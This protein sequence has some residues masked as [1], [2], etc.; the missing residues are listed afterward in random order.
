M[1]QPPYWIRWVWKTKKWPWWWPKL[2]GSSNGSK[3][4]DD[5]GGT[6]IGE[7]VD[8]RADFQHKGGAHY[9]V[10]YL[11]AYTGIQ[12][13]EHKGIGVMERHSQIMKMIE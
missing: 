6:Y 12:K 9:D 10:D 8:I 4:E 2:I 5:E 11:E 13:F 7:I 3:A 1:G